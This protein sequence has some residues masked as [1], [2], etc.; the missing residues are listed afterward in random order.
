MAY[1]KYAERKSLQDALHTLKTA[2][3]SLP[4]PSFPQPTNCLSQYHDSISKQYNTSRLDIRKAAEKA[5]TAYNEEQKVGVR[6]SV[7][8]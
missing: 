2:P 4:S 1:L 8:N 6:S 5:L 3:A 7:H